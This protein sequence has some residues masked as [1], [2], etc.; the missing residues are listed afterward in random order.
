MAATSSSRK[1]T[2]HFLSRQRDVDLVLLAPLRA[3]RLNAGQLRRVYSINDVRHVHEVVGRLT[4]G[5]DAHL[6]NGRLEAAAFYFAGPSWRRAY[7][8]ALE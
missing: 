1:V 5:V 6:S 7:G 3:H 4:G 8:G 2:Q